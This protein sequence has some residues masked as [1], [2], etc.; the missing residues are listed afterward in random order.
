MMGSSFWLAGALAESNTL[1]A[2]MV[3]NRSAYICSY[4]ALS[5]AFSR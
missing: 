3:R 5:N 1:G 2:M 4:F